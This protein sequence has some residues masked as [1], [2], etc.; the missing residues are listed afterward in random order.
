MADGAASEG[1]DAPP[2]VHGAGPS[3]GGEG[4][5]HLAERQERARFLAELCGTDPGTAA[6]WLAAA[7]FD[8]DRAHQLYCAA[9]EDEPAAKVLCRGDDQGV[10]AAARSAG[11]AAS[12]VRAGAGGA[13]C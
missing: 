3:S 5:A 10:L 8:V 12:Q 9:G 2:W 6:F 11:W 4:G 13:G 7:G 1:D